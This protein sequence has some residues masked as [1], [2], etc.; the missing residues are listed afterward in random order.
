LNGPANNDHYEKSFALLLM[1]VADSTG[2]VCRPQRRY[3]NKRWGYSSNWETDEGVN[4]EGIEIY[5][6]QNRRL[7]ILAVQRELEAV[8]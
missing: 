7:N 1:V 5:P 3:R 2:F 4:K 6:P 8:P